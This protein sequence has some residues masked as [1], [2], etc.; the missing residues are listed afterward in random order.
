MDHLLLSQEDSKHIDIIFS[1]VRVNIQ[2]SDFYSYKILESLGILMQ[3]T[4]CCNDG[5]S[6]QSLHIWLNLPS[7]SSF[8]CN[9]YNC[10]VYFLTLP[11][12]L[13]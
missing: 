11:P 9:S 13:L 8:I 2:A 1:R 5:F 10:S 12:L 6:Y 3:A 4:N 7:P